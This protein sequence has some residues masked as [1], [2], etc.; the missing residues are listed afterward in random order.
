MSLTFVI[1]F[2]ES[3]KLR[4]L[5][6]ELK[7][8][9]KKMKKHNLSIAQR[10]AEEEE[11]TSHN[12]KKPTRG[13]GGVAMRKPKKRKGGKDRE[14]ES[15]SV[16]GSSSDDDSDSSDSESGDDESEES[17]LGSKRSDDGDFVAGESSRR[18]R[19][20]VASGKKTAAAKT[21]REKKKDDDSDSSDDGPR[22]KGKKKVG[23]G[24]SN[25]QSEEEEEEELDKCEILEYRWMN[26]NRK[27][28]YF[29]VKYQGMDGAT[30]V[31]AKIFLFDYN[32]QGLRYIWMNHGHEDR[33]LQY[34]DRCA[35]GYYQS[36]GVRKR[37]VVPGFRGLAVYAGERKEWPEPDWK[38]EDA[39]KRC[40]ECDKPVRPTK[41]QKGPPRKKKEDRT[42]DPIIFG[43]C[44]GD[45]LPGG[46][47]DN[48][49]LPPGLA[50]EGVDDAGHGDV[51]DQLMAVPLMT[52]PNQIEEWGD[53]ERGGNVL[54]LDG[55]E[56]HGGR[57]LQDVIEE[58]GDR[59]N[60]TVGSAM[61]S[62]PSTPVKKVKLGR[63]GVCLLTETPKKPC[64][65]P[66][67]HDWET[68]EDGTWAKNGNRLDGKHC[69]GTRNGVVCNRAFVSKQLVGGGHVSETEYHP[70]KKYAA[71]GCKECRRVM[72][73]ECRWRY[74]NTVYA[75][76]ANKNKDAE[77]AS[78]P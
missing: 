72:C 52:S 75:S 23:S 21:N 77:A 55:E 71:Y 12:I 36:S 24:K 25:E 13:G 41:K 6:R 29:R 50:E 14:S 42:A 37:Q 70:T 73:A 46:R 2:Q 11:E 15:G 69:C 49:K 58:V 9:K 28:G 66:L 63:H 17:E 64:E 19:A 35:K 26:A 20:T 76:P 57:G 33:V 43:E 78:G 34:I 68:F 62:V 22:E 67:R 38:K 40:A 27:T 8:L 30:C 1:V 18:I 61:E 3:E 10:K 53:L 56:C 51:V 74:D 48:R 47:N 54:G 31:G 45:R 32:E 7:N 59:G 5:Q 16:A 60:E 65:L 4:A 39:T 44:F